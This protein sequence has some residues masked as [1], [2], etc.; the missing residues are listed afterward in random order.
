[1]LNMI[2]QTI[3]QQKNEQS[4][5]LKIPYIQ[6]DNLD[7]VREQIDTPLIKVVTGPRRAG[8]S[9]FSLL[10]LKD[11]NFAY[12]NFDDE[13]LVKAENYDEIVQAMFEVYPAPQYF[14]FDEIQNLPT[15]E[16]FVNKLHRRNYNILLTGSNARLLS[17]EL[18]TTLTGRYL[19]Y[20]ILPFSFR[21]FLEAKNI[22]FSKE[23]FTLPEIKGRFL[24]VFD[25]YLIKGG[26]PEIVTKG[27]D[28]KTYL[29]TL[30]DSVLLKDIVKRYKVR[31]TSKLYD[32]ATYLISNTASEFSFTKLKNILGF[33]S[34]ST[35]EKYLGYLEESYLFFVLNRFSF[36]VKQQIKAPRK[37]YLVDNGFIEAKAFQFSPDTGRLMENLAFVEFIRRGYVPNLDLFYYKTRNNREVD[38]VVR[39]ENRI[40][41]L[42]QVSHA[43]ADQKTRE[44][45]IKALREASEELDCRN[46]TIITWDKEGEEKVKDKV[47][48]FL[49]MWEWLLNT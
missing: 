11:K 36:K 2:K 35:V 34:V 32:L 33:A 48:R 6:R 16:L 29:A 40:E 39:R 9:V 1:M 31:F 41:D 3:L 37:I 25:E 27:L 47:I 45:E 12:L 28:V 44:R 30:F 21:E 7:K 5:L 14:L 8:K 19:A 42:V 13:N 22:R 4:N 20:E 23:D 43:S 46:L 38:F 15:W 24:N 17:K 10:L 49:P 26:Y 18:A